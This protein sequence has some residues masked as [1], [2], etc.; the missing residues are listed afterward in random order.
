MGSRL[1]EKHALII[2]ELHYLKVPEPLSL[3]VFFANRSKTTFSF[4]I[5]HH[6]GRQQTEESAVGVLRSCAEE[7][8]MTSVLPKLHRRYAW[9][10]KSAKQAAATAA[11]ATPA[12]AT[13]VRGSTS[14]PA[15]RVTR[16]ADKRQDAADEALAPCAADE[17]LRPGAAAVPRAPARGQEQ[18]GDSTF[19]TAEGGVSLVVVGCLPAAAAVVHDV[20]GADIAAQ[21]SANFLAAAG[22]SACACILVAAQWHILVNITHVCSPPGKPAC[23]VTLPSQ[24]HA[25]WLAACVR[26][27]PAAHS[28]PSHAGHLPCRMLPAWCISYAPHWLT[29]R[30]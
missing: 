30:L 21:C 19:E 11:G 12:P 28:T 29:G 18:V 1:D 3:E 4:K 17:V 25:L 6:S 9:Q 20:A 10:T 14:L 24:Q 5:C 26:L 22:L 7:A 16:S 2:A 13:P 23:A 8:N 15:L 27:C